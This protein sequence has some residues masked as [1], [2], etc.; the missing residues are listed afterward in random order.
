MR[1]R[2][3]SIPITAL[4]IFA[5]SGRMALAAQASPG[6]AG[7]WTLDRAL[8]QLPSEVGFGVEFVPAGGPDTGPSSSGRGRGRTRGPAAPFSRPESEDDAKRTQQ[9]TAEVRTPSVNL[10]ITETSSAVTVTDDRGRART[11]HPSGKEETIQLDNV[12]VGV[13]TTGAAAHLVVTYKVADERDLRYT[14]SRSNNPEQLIVDV[15]FIER[16]TVDSS[17]RRIYVPGTT[18]FP[19]SSTAGA[20]PAATPTPGPSDRVPPAAPAQSADSDLKGLTRLGVIVE[21]LGSQA[22]ACGLN[23]SAIEATASKSLADVGLTV[24]RNLSSNEDTYLYVNVVTSSLSTGVCV[25]RYDAFLY[26]HTTARLSYH[27]A[28]VPVQVLLLHSGGMAGTSVAGHADAVVRG[29]K[30]YIDQIAARIRDANPPS[31][32]GVNR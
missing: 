1:G 27:D 10:A 29:V 7:Q 12:P 19:S 21:G 14:Y 3:A 15:A 17:F 6:L 30:E 11:F 5:P 18:P 31:E 8:S 2:A 4:M 23:Q 16:G 9:L 26:T 20:S 22:V 32:P 24:L 28:P 25:S 13:V